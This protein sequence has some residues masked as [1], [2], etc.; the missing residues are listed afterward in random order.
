MTKRSI[1]LLAVVPAVALSM[2]AIGCKQPVLCPALDACGG[3]LP[4]GVWTLDANH[5]ACTEEP[6]TPPADPRLIGADIPAA[7]TP[8]PDPAL[9]DWCD[10]LV[11]S[12]NIPA[13]DPA[14]PHIIPLPTTLNS[15]VLR[16]PTFGFENFPV[17]QA[18]I[19]YTP[20]G[21]DGHYVMS[22]TR[23]GFFTL[24]FPTYCMRK[25]GAVDTP[26]DP[27]APPAGSG[28]V[29]T[30]L[31][32]ALKFLA[33]SS[34]RNVRCEPDQIPDPDGQEGCRCGFDVADRKES[35]GR[36]L[37]AAGATD[38]FHLPGN[39]FPEDVDFCLGNNELELTGS[40]GA[41]LFD[42]VGLRTLD[43][44]KVTPN[45]TDGKAGPGEDGVDCGPACDNLCSTIEANCSDKM[46][47]PTELGVDCGPN[48]PIQCS[49]INCNDGFQG[50]GE[51]GVDCGANC[52][53]KTCPVCDD[54]MKGPG[55]DGV[56]CGPHCP[57]FCTDINC[58]DGIKGPGEQGKDC[59]PNC[60]NPC[61]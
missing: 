58:H 56:D 5:V 27:K 1:P 55:E 32:Q 15:I 43:L 22:T 12:P 38:L 26:S 35:M 18:V 13:F 29:C 59:G 23:T 42:R 21:A 61:P 25:F 45:C 53:L 19:N 24:D 36:V 39:D 20:D 6:Y 48:C 44:V 51:D 33:P 2:A 52:P 9:Y 40:N 14:K 37:T 57:L 7:R 16:V 54:M 46:Q 30:K 28:D 11:T 17:G 4:V 31:T 8:V 34:Y 10:Y 3:G 50:P 41:Y 47:G 60:P 49:D